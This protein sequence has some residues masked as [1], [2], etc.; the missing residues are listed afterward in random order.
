MKNQKKKKNDKSKPQCSR[1]TQNR[2]KRKTK[3]K[4]KHQGTIET[5]RECE[6][7]KSFTFGPLGDDSVL[8]HGYSGSWRVT[9]GPNIRSIVET[10]LELN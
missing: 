8:E 7:S 4:R 6:E 3:Q 10:E 5:Q 1:P 9:E 2:A